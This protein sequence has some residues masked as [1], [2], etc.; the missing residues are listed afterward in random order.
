MVTDLP[1][2]VTGAAA[3]HDAT[4]YL[5]INLGSELYAI[6]GTSVREIARWREAVPVPGAPALLPGI[7]NQR[8]VVLPVVDMRVL[9]NF[10]DTPPDRATRYVIINHD[11]V[12]MAL[13]VDSVTDLITLAASDQEPPPTGLDQQQAHLLQAVA[14]W[15]N[16]LVGLL[17]PGA[18]ITTL[19]ERVLK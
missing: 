16:R 9:F 19:Q 4:S 8:G 11:E 5:L 1:V 7:I 17:D 3:E 15:E 10:P 13:L 14:H 12:D 6:Q 2:E 18:I